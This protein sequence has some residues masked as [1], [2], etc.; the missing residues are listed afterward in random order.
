MEHPHHLRL[1]MS[2]IIQF[3]SVIFLLV[4]ISLFGCKQNDHASLKIIL[5]EHPQKELVDIVQLLEDYWNSGQIESMKPY[6]AEK[7]VQMP[8][9]QPPVIGRSELFKRWLIYQ[10]NFIDYWEPYVEYVSVSGDLA[11]VRGGFMQRSVPKKGG[12]GVLMEAKSIQVF[13]RNLEGN[14]QMTLDI[15][16]TSAPKKSFTESD[17]LMSYLMSDEMFE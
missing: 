4:A 7:I 10:Q 3:I 16:N 13:E 9:N 14:W 11:V 17:K 1:I 12:Y 6:Y 5:D 2:K 15:W 8:P